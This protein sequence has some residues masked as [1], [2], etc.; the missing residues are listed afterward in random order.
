MAKLNPNKVA[1]SLGITAVV[2]YIICL[3][4]VTI[5]PLQM[6]AP[7]VNN[8]IHSVD[9]TGMMTKNITLNGSIVGIVAWFIIA[10]VTGYIFAFVYNQI[11]GKLK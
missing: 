6:M 3:I 10:A 11:E 7:F 1:L 2:L 4:L 9:F 8:L 5:F